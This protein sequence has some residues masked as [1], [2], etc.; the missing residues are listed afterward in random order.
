MSASQRFSFSAF[1]ASE[2]TCRIAGINTGFANIPCY[3]STCSDD[4]M[5]ANLN[6]ENCGIRSDANMIANFR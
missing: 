2:K 1:D 6:R 5:V 4:D 3:D